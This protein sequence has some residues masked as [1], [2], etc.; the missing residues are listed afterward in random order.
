MYLCSVNPQGELTLQFVLVLT[1]SISIMKELKC[2]NCGKVFS[3][4]E[5]DYASIVNQVKNAEFNDEVARRIEELHKQQEV[6][7]KLRTVATEQAHQSELIKKD[8]EIA[9]LKAAAELE[10][11]KKQLEEN[12]SA[13][14]MK[15]SFA[16]LRSKS[17]TTKT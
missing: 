1:K 7:E 11:S 13:M 14:T 3:V 2:P 15:T 5:A 4:D 17:I 16:L 8:Q 6:E 9:A 10:K 12:L